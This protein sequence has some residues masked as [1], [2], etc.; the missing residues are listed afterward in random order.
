[1]ELTRSQLSDIV[2]TSLTDVETTAN[3]LARHPESRSRLHEYRRVARRLDAS[4]LLGE[5]FLKP[6]D[7]ADMRRRAWRLTRGLGR[8]RD[9]DV[10]AAQVERADDAADGELADSAAW[11]VEALA[12]DAWRKKR[13]K[14][15]ERAAR[16]ARPRA[17]RRPI[18]ERLGRAVMDAVAEPLALPRARLVARARAAVD[19]GF[20][21]RA[22][23]ALRIE[24]KA[25]RDAARHLGR[26]EEALDASQLADALGILRDAFSIELSA[27]KWSLEGRARLAATRMVSE[28]LLLQQEALGVARPLVVQSTPTP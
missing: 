8:F 17:L 1:V 6:A 18:E 14:A 25:C 23:H 4:I 26:A 10:F 9:A 7:H 16:R 19:A 24:S 28:A 5:L 2:S 27:R 21:Q 15:I 11:L 22:L 3:D 13:S 20:S 12:K